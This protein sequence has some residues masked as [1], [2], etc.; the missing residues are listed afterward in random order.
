MPHFEERGYRERP[1]ITV[2]YLLTYED[3]DT[4]AK[5]VRQNKK[6]HPSWL[7]NWIRMLAQELGMQ[8]GRGIIYELFYVCKWR[9][10][11]ISLS[12]IRRGRLPQMM[13]AAR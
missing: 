11:V 2:E 9:H 10:W 7:E 6:G 3:G 1:A 4:I 13:K 12:M 5:I 8:M